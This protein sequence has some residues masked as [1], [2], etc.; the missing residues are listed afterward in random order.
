VA[1]ANRRVA[2]PKETA[3]RRSLPDA[4][5]RSVVSSA[6]AAGLGLAIVIGG[7]IAYRSFSAPGPDAAASGS[8]SAGPAAAPRCSD[9][10][11]GKSA[12]IGKAAGAAAGAGGADAERDDLLSPF[13]VIL[14]RAVALDN[15][16]AVG[17]QGEGD[18][19]TLSSVVF[20]DPDATTAETVALSSSRG[21]LDPP[22]VAVAPGGLVV[23]LI[24]PNASSRAVRLARVADKKVTWGAELREDMDESLAL[25]VA[26]AGDRGVVVWDAL[27][28]DESFVSLAGFDVNAIGNASEPRRLTPKG[29]DADAPRVVPRPGGFYAVYQVRGTERARDAARPGPAAPGD[30]SAKPKKDPK[31]KREPGEADESRGGEAVAY[32]WLEVLLLDATGA[33]SGD[34]QRLTPDD[35]HVISF[36]VAAAADGGLAVAYRDEDSP[37]GAGGG[38]VKALRIGPGGG[39]AESFQSDEGTPSDG[40]PTLLPGWMAIPTLRGADLLGRLG[41][42]GVPAEPL[43]VE[44]SLGRGE[45]IAATADRLLL[46]EPEGKAMRVRVVTCGDRPASVPTSSALPADDEL[47]PR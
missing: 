13:A 4:G 9:A 37:T 38:T 1:Y 25:D 21:D 45:P 46:A 41:A 27:D 19:G 28:D 39:V 34:A 14:G 23:A 29:V 35:G 30:S 24:E 15:G 3:G 6:L 2:E 8:A 40:A 22:V 42:G 31:T 20:I 33:P 11:P 47:N 12:A 10:A 5:G 16:W 26:V 7:A 43:M 36:D 17:V 32:T 18:T 44:A